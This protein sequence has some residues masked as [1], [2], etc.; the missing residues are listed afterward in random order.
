M[1]ERDDTSPLLVKVAADMAEHSRA[2]RRVGKFLLAAPQDFMHAAL[3]DISTAAEVSEPTVIRFC[4]HYGYKGMAD[5]RIALAMSLAGQGTSA[6]TFLEPRVSDKADVN[7]RQKTAIARAAFEL[8]RADRSIIIDSGSTTQLFAEALRNATPKTIM[9]TGLNIVETLRHS[10]QH[11]V[12]VPGGTVRFESMSLSGGLVESTLAD[13]R[14]DTLYLGADAI[15][16][17]LGL[18]TYNA[19]EARQNASMIRL[20][21]RVVVLADSTK[22]RAPGLH[23]FCEITRIDTI[24]TDSGLPVAVVESLA[25]RGVKVL[26]ADPKES[27]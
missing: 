14:F 15:D 9:T 19:L 4:R 13:M 21:Q 18:S 27:P 6:G 12:M 17:D 22:F 8:S 24:V 11:E 20:C 7:R 1:A 16:P 5:F 10:P 2:F 25:A 23:L 26:C 3:L